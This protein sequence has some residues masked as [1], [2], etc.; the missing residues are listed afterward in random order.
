MVNREQVGLEEEP[1]LHALVGRRQKH[2]HPSTTAARLVD[3]N[4]RG[5][6]DFSIPIPF[7][8]FGVFIFPTCGPPNRGGRLVV[9]WELVLANLVPVAFGI[10]IGFFL[11]P[12]QDAW[13][14]RRKRKRLAA[15]LGPEVETIRTMA[16]ESVKAH[17]KNV[18]KVRES[19]TRGGS[20]MGFVGT[21]DA[22]YPTRVYDSHLTDVDLLDVDAATRLTNLY[23]W[24]AFAHYWKRQ[25]LGYYQEFIG[26]ARA[27]EVSGTAVN[28]PARSYFA[29]VQGAMVTVAETYLRVQKR[30]ITFAREA[31]AE[32]SKA[33]RQPVPRID[34]S[35]GEDMISATPEQRKE[36]GPKSST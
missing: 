25:E 24:T 19:L 29:E 28:E 14:N 31:G 1:N 20:P 26:L 32:I 33:S 12:L 27:F 10:L 18:R 16:A 11:V 36:P 21:N 6:L 8:N 17:E 22:D 35:I 4:R 15:I 2:K 23:R 7:S 9:D 5:R 3:G 34:L 13:S 30:I